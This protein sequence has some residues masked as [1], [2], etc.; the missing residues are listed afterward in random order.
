MAED[1]DVHVMVAN[2]QEAA[3]RPTS[4]VYSLLFLG[5]GVLL[6]FILQAVDATRKARAKQA[7]P[8]RRKMWSK[9]GRAEEQAA[10]KPKGTKQI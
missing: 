7:V 4:T 9:E 8:G 2:K 6:V 3:D 1:G 10:L 5:L